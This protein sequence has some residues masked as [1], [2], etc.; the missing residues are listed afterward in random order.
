MAER[1]DTFKGK[2]DAEGCGRGRFGRDRRGAGGFGG[3]FGRSFGGGGEG[4]GHQRRDDGGI[5]MSC[6]IPWIS[7]NGEIQEV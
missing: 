7:F 1:F 3:G 4:G 6:G 5:R 2:R